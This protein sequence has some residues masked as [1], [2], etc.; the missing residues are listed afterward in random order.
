[1]PTMGCSEGNV[2]VPCNLVQT[3][4]RAGGSYQCS[5]WTC[6]TAGWDPNRDGTGRGGFF[7]YRYT[8]EGVLR[9][10]IGG[11][12]DPAYR[13]IYANLEKCMNKYLPEDFPE[14]KHKP[15]DLNIGLAMYGGR[16]DTNNSALILGLWAMESDFQLRPREDHGPM[17]L[18]SWW[19]D[20][21]DRNGLNLIVPGA[22]DPFGRPAGSPNRNRTFTGSIS[23][24]VMTAGNIIRYSQNSLRQSDRTIAY[25][26]GPGSTKSAQDNVKT[27]N[28]YTNHA[29]R[30]KDR[31]VA[32]I[33][34]LKTGQ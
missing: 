32:L 6:P 3:S 30:L 4:L 12:Q 15:D 31:Y 25:M 14:D 10:S 34:C 22:Y 1:M 18:T 28:E 17:G 16:D 29:M 20:Y 21:S 8:D 33:N 24:N 13:G 11:S 19:K 23:A 9:D 27:R 7:L 2:P 26:Y 5:G